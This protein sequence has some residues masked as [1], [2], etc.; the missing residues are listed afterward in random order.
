[1]RDI[2]TNLFA[3]A[4]TF[5]RILWEN[6]GTETGGTITRFSRGLFLGVHLRLLAASSEARYA[7]TV[8][9]HSNRFWFISIDSG[10][11]TS[12]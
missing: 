10:A 5:A 9:L 6:F 7:V 8:A 4:P 1:L 11:A 2:G 12:L 3:D